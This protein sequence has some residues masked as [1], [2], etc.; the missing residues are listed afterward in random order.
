MSQ[1]ESCPSP[2]PSEQLARSTLLVTGITIISRLL[3]FA[4]DVV[5]AYTLGGSAAADVFVAVF[6]IPNFV[7]RLVA[8]GAVS[9]PFIPEYCRRRNQGELE[10]GSAEGERRAM[11]F[12][13][14]AMLWVLLVFTPLCGLG[15]IFPDQAMLLVA[16]GFI[17]R[18]QS[19]DA[20]ATLM[21]LLLPYTLILCTLA[22]GGGI[23]QSRGR[24]LSPVINPCIPN[25][26]VLLA[27]GFAIWIG[28]IHLY[29]LETGEP[30]HAALIFCQALIFSGLL[31]WVYVGNN[32]RQ[33]KL[34]WPGPVQLKPAISFIKKVPLSLCGTATHQANI[35]I[36][37]MGASFLAEGAVAQFHYADQLITLP[38]GMFGM[39]IGIIALPKFTE[40]A[41]QDRLD[42]LRLGLTDNM[43]LGLYLSL[44]AA[45]GLAGIADPL[46][47]ILFMRGAF[48]VSAAHGTALA[49]Q[50]SCLALPAL[51]IARPLLAA[52][53]VKGYLKL[54]AGA[55][56]ISM[57]STAALCITLP[58]AFT[59]F[60]APSLS[61]FGIGLAVSAG[62][63]V[64]ALLLWVCLRHKKLTPKPGDLAS[65]GLPII[66]CVVIFAGT[67]LVCE[68][69][70]ASPWMKVGTL[71]SL[72]MLIYFFI[73]NAAGCPE[74]KAVFKAFKK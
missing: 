68:R 32:M 64:F 52:C 2:I 70:D 26:V 49:L 33:E 41:S 48:D 12:C 38:L 28:D 29:P 9:M 6:R 58:K 56:I 67:W 25:V 3:G 13:R 4:R 30:A 14:S 46:V 69:L 65:M 50:G 22:I 20:A 16:P 51:A 44:P 19:I 27:M 74:A 43:A 35:L 31:Q 72:C 61:I 10:G 57:A 8:E 53:H 71:V 18:P 39:A 15:M 54:A 21:R 7:R 36:A 34:R 23:M 59:A 62:A 47:T 40:L 42:D 63:W 55:G 1:Q 17:H 37:G 66:L 5:I 60:A 24:F 73:T 45:A 11:L